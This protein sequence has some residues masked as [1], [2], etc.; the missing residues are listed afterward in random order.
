[1]ISVSGPFPTSRLTLH[2]IL[3]ISKAVW[4]FDHRFREPRTTVREP[5]MEQNAEIPLTQEEKIVIMLLRQ[6]SY[7]VAELA[8]ALCLNCGHIRS[9][10]SILDQKVGLV[11][12]SRSGERRYGLAE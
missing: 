7:S 2:S 10:L 4:H 11:S 3:P 6:G 9:L 1:M 5:I 12:L 8:Q